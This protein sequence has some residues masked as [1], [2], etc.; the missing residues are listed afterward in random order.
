M[1]K[2][3]GCEWG[4]GLWRNV[5]GRAREAIHK[6]QAG[7]DETYRKVANAVKRRKQTRNSTQAFWIDYSVG[8]SY[9]RVRDK[10]PRSLR[11]PP[12]QTR[13]GCPP[14]CPVSLETTQLPCE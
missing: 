7:Q 12:P 5:E 13:H 8:F 9:N 11:T 14:T 6:Q 10:V 4:T 3:G 2:N 1:D